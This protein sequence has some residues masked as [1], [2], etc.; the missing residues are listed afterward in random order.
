MRRQLLSNRRQVQADS[1]RG[2]TL[3]ELLVTITIFV[4]LAGL[5]MTAFNAAASGDRVPSASRTLQA[6][7][8]GAKSRAA[9]L[10][11]PVGLRAVIE[12]TPESL[13][14]RLCRE[15]EYV[16]VPE[17]LEGNLSYIENLTWTNPGPPVQTIDQ[18]RVGQ[19]VSWPDALAGLAT[20]PKD[21]QPWSLIDGGLQDTNGDG[22]AGDVTD[23]PQ[24]ALVQPGSRI[25]IPRNSGRWY[26]IAPDDPRTPGYSEFGP[27]QNELANY[28]TQYADPTVANLEA[29][30]SLPGALANN[31]LTILPDYGD[32][33]FETTYPSVPAAPPWTF[34][35]A[36]VFDVLIEATGSHPATAE[37]NS[38]NEHFVPAAT[39]GFTPTPTGIQGAA[40]P[41]RRF[42]A[43]R[44]F[45]PYRM[46]LAPDV[47]DGSKNVRLPAG[48]WIDLDATTFAGRPG[49]ATGS[50]APF[51]VLFS[52]RGE[53][54]GPASGLGKVDFYLTDQDTLQAMRTTGP[55]IPETSWN[56]A[57]TGLSSG[58]HPV[59]ATDAMDDYS[60]WTGVPFV[61]S[62]PLT[63]HRVVSLFTRTGFV[64]TSEVNSVDL[65]NNFTGTATPDGWADNPYL[66]TVQGRGAE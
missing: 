58:A 59:N 17:P 52:P 18:W 37:Q 34:E 65:V 23:T 53:V 7:F 11:R 5:S 8:E 50:Y 21:L 32:A 45:V 24:L 25:E 33:R 54:I 15:F 22:V 29:P 60:V 49:T 30:E 2:F 46:E 6:A 12:V 61:P 4:I 55:D 62:V 44:F 14:G 57:V 38:V 28:P 36:A 27:D 20:D 10:G 19:M 51:T 41:G 66:F 47:L 43:N 26:V 31:Y 40:A 9:A 42:A 1:R 35:S 63:E 13:G 3:V 16:S 56:E 48:V 64:Q 39:G